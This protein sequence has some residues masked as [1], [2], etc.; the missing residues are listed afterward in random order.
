[1]LIDFWY[2]FASI[3]DISNRLRR[4]HPPW[5]ELGDDAVTIR[6]VLSS[7]STAM[8]V[9]L[10]FA[11]ARRLRYDGVE[12]LPH[13]FVTAD[14][15]RGLEKKHGIPVTA[16]HLPWWTWR[17]ALYWMGPRSTWRVLRMAWQQAHG[18]GLLAA[19]LRALLQDVL[20]NKLQ[21]LTWLLIMGPLGEGWLCNPGLRIARELGVPVVVHPGPILE[22][23]QPPL[24]G[25]PADPEE[26][27]DW[28]E[29]VRE[30]LSIFD[31]IAEVRVENND[32]PFHPDSN[33]GEGIDQTLFCLGLLKMA[34][35]ET[36]LVL[37]WEHLAKEVGFWGAREIERKLFPVL[38]RLPRGSVAETHICGYDPRAGGV[39]AGGHLPLGQGQFPIWRNIYLLQGSGACAPILDVVVETPPGV[40]AFLSVLLLGKRGGATYLEMEFEQEDNKE[41]L[42]EFLI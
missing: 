39:K 30:Q 32:A 38:R 41:L 24:G 4:Y 19:T 12:I 9:L 33:S 14:G 25:W 42:D 2:G 37:D 27:K 34:G 8:N 15:L 13:R 11:L 7:A 16:I 6:K 40:G 3:V 31:T 28:A 35:H 22:L 23:V 1:M 10:A 18:F 36:S 29:W 17:G 21:T 26:R 20:L 5:A